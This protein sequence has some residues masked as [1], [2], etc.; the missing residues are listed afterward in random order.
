ML[1]AVIH[2]FHNNSTRER[3]AVRDEHLEYL[4]G[5]AGR[6]KLAGPLLERDDEGDASGSLIIIDAQ[7][8]GAARL[9]ANNDPYVKAEIVASTEVRAW[10]AVIGDWMP[11]N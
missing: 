9:V 8:H 7:S 2:R 3:L 1:F 6:L 5:A 10:K 11:G 4:K